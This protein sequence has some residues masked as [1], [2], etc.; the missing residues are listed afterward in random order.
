MGNWFHELH[1]IADELL[2]SNRFVS[3]TTDS[4]GY[5][6]LE[7]NKG[8]VYRLDEDDATKYTLSCFRN[9]WQLE[10]G[11]DPHAMYSIARDTSDMGEIASRVME[12]I[13]ENES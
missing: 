7:T 11:H 1:A 2:D 9:R 5:I 8:G 4:T 10:S 13:E 12:T 3:T 6:E